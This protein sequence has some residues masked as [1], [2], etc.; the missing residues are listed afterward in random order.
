METTHF[1]ASHAQVP[2]GSDLYLNYK[3]LTIMAEIDMAN[4]VII[5]LTVVPYCRQHNDFVARIVKGKSLDCDLEF[6]IKQIEIRTHT[7]TNRALI[8]ALRVL[9]NRYLAAKKKYFE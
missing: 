4:G 8:N 6:I 3:Y 1:F 9:H 5:D 7:L 2:E